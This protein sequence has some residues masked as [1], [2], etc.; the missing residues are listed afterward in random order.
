MTHLIAG[1][2][3]H[4]AEPATCGRPS[5]GVQLIG[6]PATGHAERANG[7]MGN[8]PFRRLA[9]GKPSVYENTVISSPIDAMKMGTTKTVPPELDLVLERMHDRAHDAENLSLD[10]D[11]LCFTLSSVTTSRT[12]PQRDVAMLCRQVERLRDSAH[13][14]ARALAEI[15]DLRQVRDDTPPE[16]RESPPRQDVDRGGA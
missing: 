11:A 10:L 9:S 7:C 4:F 2:R 6:A 14:L 15:R 8:D 13:D 3:A 16:T 1:G 12:L 5:I